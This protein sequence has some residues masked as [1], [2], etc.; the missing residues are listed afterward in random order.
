MITNSIE[1][2]KSIKEKRLEAGLSQAKLEKISGLGREVVWKLEVS[3]TIPVEETI[4]RICGS[5]CFHRREI[6][7]FLDSAKQQRKNRDK[8]QQEYAIKCAKKLLSRYSV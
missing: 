1:I 5:L 7:E 6:H 8:F 3:R 2:G 4:W